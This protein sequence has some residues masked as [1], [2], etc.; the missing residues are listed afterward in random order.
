MD[1]AIHKGRPFWSGVFDANDGFI[2]EVHPYKRAKA[3]DFHHSYYVS[4]QSQDAMKQGDAG[5]FW[6]D[7]DGSVNTDWREGKAPKHIVDAIQDQIE[8]IPHKDNGGSISNHPD[9]PDIVYH[10]TDKDIS[11]GFN[12]PAFFASQPE[13][14]DYYANHRGEGGGR[15]YPIKLNMA[16]PLDARDK[17]GAMNLIDI[18]RRAG[19]KINVNHFP[20]G[21]WDFDTDEISKHSDYE[22]S[23]LNDLVYSPRVR[24]QMQKEGYDGLMAWDQLSN[25]EIPIFVALHNHQIKSAIGKEEG[26]GI[27]AYQGGP[28]SVGEEG[29]LDEKI[30]TGEGAQ[31]YGHGHYFAEN[32]DIAKGYRD[33]LTDRTSSFRVG[34]IDMP[35][36]ILKG[37]ESAPDKNAAIEKHRQDFLKRLGEDTKDQ[38]TSAQPWMSAARISSHKDILAGL[39]QLQH[40]SDVPHTKGHMHEVIINAHPDHFLD[41]DQPIH[42]QTKHVQNALSGLNLSAGKYGDTPLGAHIYG[43]LTHKFDQHDPEMLNAV[44]NHPNQL[45]QAPELASALLHSKGIKGIRYLDAGSRNAGEGTRNYVVFDPKIVDIKRR[46]EQGGEVDDGDMS[47]NTAKYANENSLLQPIGQSKMIGDEKPMFDEGIYKAG[48]S[49]FTSNN[50]K[51]IRYLHHDDEGNPIGALQIMTDGPRSK[52]ATIQNVYV[53]EPFRRSK[54]ATGLLN[55]AR[56]DFDVKHSTDLTNDG[57]SFAKAVKSTGGAIDL[58]RSVRPVARLKKT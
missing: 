47:G 27:T 51:S 15:I 28:H 41:W 52:K 56:R 58:A 53:A 18:A 38:E 48:V 40:G 44:R 33:R 30:G 45:A 36:W 13:H 1:T 35:K 16:N 57:R 20:D 23:N 54:I 39:D 2:R 26:G 12:I 46:Y 37:I 17:E 32:E 11:G 10:G 43:E 8:P 42:N 25:D 4:S 55:R 22:G 34:N 6:V 31:A 9:I 50:R 14:A 29:F 49:G 3:A 7:P 24:T 21:T 5:F 19:A